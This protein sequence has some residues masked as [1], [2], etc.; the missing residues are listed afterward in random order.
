MFRTGSFGHLGIYR[1][2]RVMENCIAHNDIDKRLLGGPNESVISFFP[3]YFLFVLYFS[4]T[5]R[6]VTWLV[7]ELSMLL[8]NHNMTSLFLLVSLLHATTLL[9]SPYWEARPGSY[10]RHVFQPQLF[11]PDPP[12]AGHDASKESPGKKRKEK[13]QSWVSLHC[14]H[15]LEPHSADWCLSCYLALIMMND[16][17]IV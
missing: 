8:I 17:F 3:L 10:A 6:V 16:L 11:Q 5:R 4:S 7:C 13:K 12:A 9:V 2:N 14:P 1:I 15:S